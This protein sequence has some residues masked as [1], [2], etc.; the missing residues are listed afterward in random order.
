MLEKSIWNERRRRSFSRSVV[1][2]LVGVMLMSGSGCLHRG[3]EPCPEPDWSASSPPPAADPGNE[4]TVDPT[5]AA[6]AVATN[7]SASQPGPV[8]RWFQG[9]ARWIDA[10]LFFPPRQPR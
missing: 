10:N 1:G 5:V 8:G 6:P 3:P 9:A 4:E 2:S 7:E